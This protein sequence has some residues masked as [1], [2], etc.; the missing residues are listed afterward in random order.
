MLLSNDG[1]LPLDRRPGAGSRVAVIGPNAH[2]AEALQGCYSFANHVLADHPELP[3]GFEI[4]TVFESLPGA[5]EAAGLAVINWA[6]KAND[7]DWILK[8]NGRKQT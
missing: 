7:W 2:R 5:F 8:V 4:P 1:V 3:L 6:L